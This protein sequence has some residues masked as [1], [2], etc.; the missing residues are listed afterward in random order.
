MLAGDP[1]FTGSTAH[2]IVARHLV[3]PPP[4]LRTVRHTVSPALEAAVEKALEK[5]PADRFATAGEFAEA[6]ET[7][8]ATVPQTWLARSLLRMAEL[9]GFRVVALVGMLLAV[10]GG[11]FAIRHSGLGSKRPAE[12]NVPTTPDPRRIAVLYF[13]DSSETKDLQYLADGL[14]EKL[15]ED[16]RR[17][18]SVRVISQYGV[19][20]YRD[21]KA[22]LDSIARAL[23]VGTLVTGVLAS[24]GT[25]VRVTVTVIDGATGTSVGGSTFEHS[26]EVVALRSSLLTEIALD[27]RP[28]LGL[29]VQPSGELH[30]TH[31]A[32]A[33]DLVFN[34][35]AA[36]GSIDGLLAA[37]DTAAATRALTLA[38]SLLARAS[39][40]DRK[41]V[42]PVVERG[43]VAYERRKIVGWEKGPASDWT[44]RALSF[45]DQALRIEV[46]PEA[47]RLRGTVRY[48]RWLL[49]LDPSPLTSRQ[50]LDSAAADLRAGGDSTSPNGASAWAL[51][52][53]LYARTSDP[54]QSNLAALR[55]MEADPYLPDA[56]EL[57]YRAFSSSVDREDG[58]N[59][60]QWCREGRRRFP[61]DSYF[62]ECQLDLM[63]L[64]G[65]KVDVQRAWEI[66]E[67]DVGL[68]PPN[69]RDFRRRRDQ[70][71]MGFVLVNA[72]LRDSA[73]HLALRS[74]AD[75]TVD[76]NR[77]LLYFEAALRN[78]LGDRDESLR[79]LK[80]YLTANPQDRSTIANDQSYWW[81]GVREDP[82]FQQLVS[83]R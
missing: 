11:L 58:T 60:D 51:L 1:P 61:K 47:H 31:D 8:G 7:A 30:D 41:W 5:V 44:R 62:T 42:M 9:R 19:A 24:S 57:L 64:P 71:L 26:R 83:A 76:P 18:P 50:L 45:A 68:W 39:A 54:A 59:A 34:A 53:H 72:G 6:I 13:V 15:I 4:R 16:L 38:D 82:R 81:R 28:R 32:G 17:A 43:W 63:A 70:M 69:A 29:I 55:A 74:R 20:P 23:Q 36:R 56:N 75:T 48:I 33:W 66:L 2:A 40:M 10:I 14:T 22:S 79:L 67:D 52:S 27:L 3:D 35:E 80:L 49:A 78:L 21:S 65:Q 12:E 25:R 73:D 46:D 37:A 77:E